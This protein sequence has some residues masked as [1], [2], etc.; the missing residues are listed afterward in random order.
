MFCGQSE[1]AGYE[2]SPVKFYRTRTLAGS[3]RDDHYVNGDCTGGL[4]CYVI[5]T[6]GGYCTQ[7]PVTCEWTYLGT[8]DMTGDCDSPASFPNGSWPDPVCDIGAGLMGYSQEMFPVGGA[9]QSVSA[10][11][12]EQYLFDAGCQTGGRKTVSTSATITLSDE[13]TPADAIVRLLA[14]SSW[15]A[16]ADPSPG[17]CTSSWEEFPMFP[18][19]FN[20]TEAQFRYSATGLTPSTSYTLTL[21]VYESLYGMG[22]YSMVGTV[23]AGFTTDGSGNAIITGNVPIT[24]GY[25]TY[26]ANPVVT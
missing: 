23:T 3:W 11:I 18:G 17:F 16:W 2:S 13:D 4:L 26:V 14:L 15:S 8:L 22:S 6:Y 5:G 7:D 9:L 24:L 10:L 21:D 19:G 1:F 12:Q 25:D 20:Y